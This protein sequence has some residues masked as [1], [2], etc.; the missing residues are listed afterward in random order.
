[1][2]TTLTDTNR[3]VS[4]TVDKED[5]GDLTSTRGH[6]CKMGDRESADTWTTKKNLEALIYSLGIP[7]INLKMPDWPQTNQ[8]YCSKG[9]VHAKYMI[10]AFCGRLCII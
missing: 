8:E 6:K 10:I 7:H 5:L 3:E 4:I 1:M 9:Y 2:S